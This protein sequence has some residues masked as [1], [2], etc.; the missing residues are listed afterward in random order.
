MSDII[1][2]IESPF[3]TIA[4]TVAGDGEDILKTGLNDVSSILASNFLY[5]V[6]ILG[7]GYIL[8]TQLNKR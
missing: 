8:L 1:G 5:P 6:L 7:G 2:A 3:T 4:G